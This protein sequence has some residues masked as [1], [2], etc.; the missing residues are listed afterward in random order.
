MSKLP[1]S[2]ILSSAR[3]R[4]TFKSWG[5]AE[6]IIKHLE[7]QTSRA[8]QWQR[9]RLPMQETGVQSLGREDPLEEEMAT[10]SGTLAWEIPWT[11]QLGQATVRGVAN[12]RAQLS[13]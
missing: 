11:E 8:A 7:S 5:E 6:I 13:N 2:D 4:K 9:T 3:K 12:S 10:H 1:G